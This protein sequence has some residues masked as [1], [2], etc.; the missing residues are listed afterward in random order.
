[1]STLTQQVF[2]LTNLWGLSSL[3]PYADLSYNFTLFGF[4]NEKPIVLK[5]SLDELSLEREVMALKAFKD[6]VAVSV[7]DYQ[8][9]AILLQRAMPGTSLKGNPNAIEVACNLIKNLNKAPIPIQHHF[10]NVLDWLVILDKPWKMPIDYLETARSLKDQLLKN[11][12]CQVL[13]HGDLHQN[14]I[15]SHEGE[16][17]II[18]PKGIIG[19]PINEVWACVENIDHDLKYISDFFVF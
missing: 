2:E 18:D 1:M 17:L 7:L 19:F 4:Q 14:N 3:Q 6:F 13:L 16:W 15:L 5:L 11:S 10:P 12:S 8:K 9:N